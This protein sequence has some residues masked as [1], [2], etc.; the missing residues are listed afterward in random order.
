MVS[1]YE[2]VC[3]SV[4]YTQGRLIAGSSRFMHLLP[5]D[6]IIVVATAILWVW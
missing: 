4:A 6:D 2:T 5:S 1:A 3:Q